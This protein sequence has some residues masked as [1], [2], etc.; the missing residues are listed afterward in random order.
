MKKRK[1]TIFSIVCMVGL[2]V[3][4]L[5][6]CYM[7]FWGVTSSVKG[8]LEFNDNI[9]GLPQGFEYENYYN[10][11]KYFTVYSKKQAANVYI[12]GMFLYSLLYA[13][14]C[15]FATTTAC[16]L[17]GY[18]TARFP[19][20]FNKIIYGFV[21]I[22]MVLPLVGSLPSEIV[23]FRTLGLYDTMFGVWISKFHFISVYFMVFSAMFKGISPSFSEA[24]KIDGASNTSIFLQ[25]MLPLIKVT[26]YTI[27]LLQ[28][29][30]YW[31]DY[32]TPLLMLPSYP[33]LALGLYYYRFRAPSVVKNTPSQLAG[34][35]IV[36]LPVLIM[37]IIFQDKLIGNV[38]MGGLKE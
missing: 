6:L 29:V 28:F 4:V 13:G 12:D 32:S 33:N 38:S 11:L 7:L 25:I 2:L 30:N 1:V 26:F 10:A 31:N 15:A 20:A 16:C 18:A 14:G 24:A 21:V 5:L 19:Y 35:I 22:A 23:V 8:R 17:M 9:L 34:C 37:F 27:F 36:F 3:Y